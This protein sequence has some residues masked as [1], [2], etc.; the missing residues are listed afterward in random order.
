M[1]YKAYAKA[2][3]A[4]AKSAT[5][6]MCVGII[7]PWGSGK[8]FLVELLKLEFDKTVRM[9]RSNF[10]LVQWFEDDY[11]DESLVI[12][13]NAMKMT[14]WESCKYRLVILIP[15]CTTPWQFII[16]AFMEYY[17]FATIL[18]LLLNDATLVWI[19]SYLFLYKCWYL[20]ENIVDDLEAQGSF[21][22][23]PVVEEY[24]I[25]NFNAWL[26]NKSDELCLNNKGIISSG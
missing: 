6:P 1:G 15:Y 2:I 20:K 25:V 14:C 7:G 17:W 10:D 8:S 5:P 19:N 26:F 12:N 23:K 16:R 22:P 18:K 4:T 24:V 13:S 11:Y 21:I 9:R 3:G